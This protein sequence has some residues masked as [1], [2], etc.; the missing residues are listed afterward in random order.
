M[1]HTDNFIRTIVGDQ[2]D[3][4]AGQGTSHP[5][6]VFEL[7]LGGLLFTA[8]VWATL[9]VLKVAAEL[10]SD[11]GGVSMGLKRKR[12]PGPLGA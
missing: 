8:A 11:P 2:K 7:L 10:P 4:H 3:R 9:M 5:S 6:V 12:K 1:K